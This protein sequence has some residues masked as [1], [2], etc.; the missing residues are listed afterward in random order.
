MYR[1]KRAARDKT[2]PRATGLRAHGG[3]WL[4]P[5]SRWNY[6]NRFRYLKPTLR[7]ATDN[8]VNRVKT[9]MVNEPLRNSPARRLTSGAVLRKRTRA[10][11]CRPSL[12]GT[13]HDKPETA[14]GKIIRYGWRERRAIGSA[15]A[16]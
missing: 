9:I 16:R 11:G 7:R 5:A 1:S 8:V 13:K 15:H 14:G 10:A 2:R 6:P 12:P 4:A 3:P